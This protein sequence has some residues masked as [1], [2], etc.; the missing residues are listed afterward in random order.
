MTWGLRH[1]PIESEM[2][3]VY[4][5]SIATSFG[6]GLACTSSRPRTISR[7][8]PS[9][10]RERVTETA[11]RKRRG[12][13]SC[14]KDE[15]G[16]RTLPRTLTGMRSA[17]KEQ[18]PESS[19]CIRQQI[20]LKNRNGKDGPDRHCAR[21]PIHKVRGSRSRVRFERGYQKAKKDHAQ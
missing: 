10:R 9:S 17:G 6:A 20:T 19:L 8:Y 12:T 16:A 3:V 13:R 15:T 1:S 7:G 21:Q 5:L 14:G 4:S 11:V 2:K 18:R